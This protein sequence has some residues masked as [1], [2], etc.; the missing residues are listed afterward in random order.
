MYLS[1]KRNL[2]IRIDVKEDLAERVTNHLRNFGFDSFVGGSVRF[3]YHSTESDVDVVV[4]VP[5]N[6]VNFFMQ[7]VRRFGYPVQEDYVD[8]YNNSKIKVIHLGTDIDL[9]TISDMEYFD[10]E[11]NNHYMVEKMLYGTSQPYGRTLLDYILELK[12]KGVRGSTIYQ[13]LVVAARER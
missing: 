3:G 1:T 9:L 2:N 10:Q 7:L 13:M 5:D 8:I 6:K 11:K 4:Y 12:G